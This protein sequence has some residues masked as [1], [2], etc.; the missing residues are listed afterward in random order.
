LICCG[1]KAGGRGMRLLIC[2]YYDRCVLKYRDV[3]WAG[4]DGCG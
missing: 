2:C 1:L 4:C 3:W